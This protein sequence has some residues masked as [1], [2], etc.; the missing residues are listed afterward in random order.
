MGMRGRL[1]RIPT[2]V[3]V[4][5]MGVPFGTAM[6]ISVKNDG[7]STGSAVLAGILLGLFFG[8]A[9][10]LAQNRQLPF[11]RQARGAIPSPTLRRAAIRAVRGGPVPADPEVRM[12]AIRLAES[13][14]EL[15]HRQRRA[16]LI[17]WPLLLAAAIAS[18]LADHSP[19]W[20]IGLVAIYLSL[21]G[22]QI[23]R[24]RM[25]RSRLKELTQGV[26]EDRS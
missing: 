16:S 2:W 13:Q 11:L 9:M 15:L 24:P 4:P 6:G 7:G 10:T 14:L 1:Q 3:L 12:A 19:R 26:E 8:L 22:Y 25:L 5:L 17:V 18:S 20:P 21:I 23:V